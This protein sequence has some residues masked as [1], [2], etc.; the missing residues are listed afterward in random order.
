MMIDYKVYKERQ[1]ECAKKLRKKLM[2]MEKS[3][4][5]FAST[6][7]VYAPEIL[8]ENNR[9]G[10]I[11]DENLDN[12]CFCISQL[13]DLMDILRGRQSRWGNRNNFHTPIMN[14]IDEFLSNAKDLGD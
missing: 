10:N 13:E 12:L 5:K 4:S 1:I 2:A 14:V 8:D 7:S 3:L 6:M 9:V 11:L